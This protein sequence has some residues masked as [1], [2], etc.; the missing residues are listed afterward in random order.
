SRTRTRCT[1]AGAGSAVADPRGPGG[2][3]RPVTRT[4]ESPGRRG[5]YRKRTMSF[6]RP[7]LRGNAGK[8]FD[9]GVHQPAG[10]ARSGTGPRVA[11][12]RGLATA[13]FRIVRSTRPRRFDPA[14]DGISG[15]CADSTTADRVGRFRTL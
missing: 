12:L 1:Y 2:R 8:F 11:A 7:F 14:R 15:G 10:R 6:R 13:D 9:R 5:R 4:R 3:T